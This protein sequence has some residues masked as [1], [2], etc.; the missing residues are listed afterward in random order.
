MARRLERLAGGLDRRRGS[1]AIGV[2]ERGR[3]SASRG[4]LRRPAP[5]S[6]HPERVDAPRS[7][8]G[9][10][11]G[12]VRA[13]DARARRRPRR[14]PASPNHPDAEIPR[15]LD[16][17]AGRGRPIAATT[18]T[19]EHDQ[20]EP[21]TSAARPRH[22]GIRRSAGRAPA[23]APVPPRRGPRA[24]APTVGE[25]VAGVGED[26]ERVEDGR[27]RATPTT[28]RPALIASAVA[29]PLPVARRGEASIAGEVNALRVRATGARLDPRP[30]TARWRLRP[31]RPRRPA[32][33]PDRPSRRRRLRGVGGDLA[34]ASSRRSR[35][36]ATCIREITS[37]GSRPCPRTA[38]RSSR[39]GTTSPAGTRASGRRGRRGPS[40]C[41]S[42]RPRPGRP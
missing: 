40:A 1:A 27:R 22:G 29:H 13:R 36:S 38:R 10:P 20:G 17:P 37:A 11:R 28:S 24:I 12:Y 18:M 15:A 42:P 6:D 23:S 32:G 14:L 9:P 34:A 31:R 2:R 7:W 21:L 16:P 39:R 3:R 41:A 30:W 4:R 5:A 25:H 8:P 35:Y 19:R 33:P 26:R